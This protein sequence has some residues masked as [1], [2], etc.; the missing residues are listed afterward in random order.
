[1]RQQANLAGECCWQRERDLLH[2]T[3]IP[4]R[5]SGATQDVRRSGHFI[6]ISM[7]IERMLEGVAHHAGE[8][9]RRRPAEMSLEPSQ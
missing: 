5:W 1:M 6:S 7:G 8:P 4:S 3:R 2:G 9:V